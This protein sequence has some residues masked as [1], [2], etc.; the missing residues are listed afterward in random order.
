MKRWPGGSHIV[1]QS[2]PRVPGDIS[3]MEIGDTYNSWKVLL[4]LDTEKTEVLIQVIPI[5]IISLKLISMFLFAIFFSPCMLVRYFNGY[6][7]VEKKRYG[8]IA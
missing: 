7:S 4:F 3:L 8:N 2:T 6:N 5:N 1:L